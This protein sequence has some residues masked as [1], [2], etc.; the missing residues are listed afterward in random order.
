M[1]RMAKP[2]KEQ[3]A[4]WWLMVREGILDTKIAKIGD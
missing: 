3:K 2:P 4:S 1:G